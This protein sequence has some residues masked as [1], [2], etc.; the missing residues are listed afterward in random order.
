MKYFTNGDGHRLLTISRNRIIRM[1]FICCRFR[2]YIGA[3][4]THTAVARLRLR[5]LVIHEALFLFT[6]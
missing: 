4:H 3:F 5:Q 2:N 6:I 1:S